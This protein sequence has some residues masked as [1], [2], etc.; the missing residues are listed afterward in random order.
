MSCN[1]NSNNKTSGRADEEAVASAA[2]G[3]DQ[4]RISVKQQTIQQRSQ[5]GHVIS[6]RVQE[7]S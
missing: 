4:L 3:L 2:D 1:R 5:F 7:F 6:S